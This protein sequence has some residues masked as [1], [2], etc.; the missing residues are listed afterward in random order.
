MQT[1]SKSSHMMFIVTAVVDFD[2]NKKGET[3]QRQ[4]MYTK[5]PDKAIITKDRKDMINVNGST[6][7]AK[8]VLIIKKDRYVN[9]SVKKQGSILCEW[10]YWE[11]EK[12]ALGQVGMSNVIILCEMKQLQCLLSNNKFLNCA[13]TSNH[14]P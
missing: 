2:V 3:H 14:E 4:W 10:E 5:A 9:S 7:Y 12:I 6:I 8:N 11:N 13:A 1:N